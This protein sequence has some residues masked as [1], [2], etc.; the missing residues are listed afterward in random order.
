MASSAIAIRKIFP[1]GAIPS[2]RRAEGCAESDIIVQKFGERPV[3]ASLMP[4]RMARIV[5][6]ADCKRKRG[7]NLWF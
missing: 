7:A 4:S 3:R 6:I 1:V 5:E 2:R